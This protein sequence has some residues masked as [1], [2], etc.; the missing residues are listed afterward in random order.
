MRMDEAHL[1]RL[2]VGVVPVAFGYH[3]T[4]N[5]GSAMGSELSE[6]FAGVLP[7]GHPPTGRADALVVARQ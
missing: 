2:I 7:T 6:I 4:A 3:P 1:V 5:K